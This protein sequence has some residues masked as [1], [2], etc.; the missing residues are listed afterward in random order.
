MANFSTIPFTGGVISNGPRDLTWIDISP[1]KVALVYTA[2][3]SGTTRH[4]MIQMV[5]F[6]GSSAPVYA[7]PCSLGTITNLTA[8]T[9]MRGAF[10]RDGLLIVTIPQSYTGSGTSAVPQKYTYNAVAYDSQDRFN[11]LSSSA[12]IGTTSNTTW[13]AHEL[14]SYNGRAFSMFRDTDGTHRFS[15]ITVDGGNAVT[16]TTKQTLTTVTTGVQQVTATSRKAGGFWCFMNNAHASVQ[17]ANLCAV[18]DMTAGTAT[19]VDAGYMPTPGTAATSFGTSR[20]VT[21]TGLSVLDVFV[22]STAYARYNLTGAQVSTQAF[23]TAFTGGVA[24]VMWLDDFHFMILNTS[25]TAMTL[26]RAATVSN[27][28]MSIQVCR[29]DE[30]NNTLTVSGNPL[31]L[32]T[33]SQRE[34]YGPYLH[35]IDASNIAVIGGY[36]YSTPSTHYGYGIQIISI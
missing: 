17:T 36:Q 18:V 19:R 6:S 11:L 27:G 15:E 24:D 16:V 31:S 13:P 3:F 35:K 2:V 12:S 9:F 14:S 33:I 30:T 22:S 26:D 34:N 4:V 5:T 1:T 25:A 10:L 8:Q 32:G 21:P 20:F 7:T 23:R 28:N 29:F